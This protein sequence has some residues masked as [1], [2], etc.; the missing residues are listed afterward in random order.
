MA[1][2]VEVSRDSTKNGN[3]NRLDSNDRRIHDWYRF[4][5][6]FPPHLVREYVRKFRLRAN[7][8]V[9]DPFCGTGTTVVECKRLGLRSIGI[10]ANPMAAYASEVK[11]DW[12]PDPDELRK[13][14]GLERLYTSVA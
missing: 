10:E 3:R 9:L 12:S 14:S 2:L 8:V 13:T 5:L 4:V 1:T 7:S 11:S 6:S